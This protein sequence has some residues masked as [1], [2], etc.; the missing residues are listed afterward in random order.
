MESS[1][2]RKSIRSTGYR[3]IRENNM[4]MEYNIFIIDDYSRLKG[5][6]FNGYNS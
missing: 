2:L 4:A 5:Q 6:T 3:T 1:F